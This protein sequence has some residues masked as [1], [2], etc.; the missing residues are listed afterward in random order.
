MT[1]FTSFKQSPGDT[2]TLLRERMRQHL[3]PQRPFHYTSE[4]NLISDEAMLRLL[5]SLQITWDSEVERARASYEANRPP[6]EP[7]FEQVIEQGW[8]Q[9]SW[10]HIWAPRDFQRA[11]RE[12]TDLTAL[13]DL[14]AR[15]HRES[16][17]FS[18]SFTG[19]IELAEKIAEIQA[20]SMEPRHLN[21]LTPAW[22]AARLWEGR[23]LGDISVAL[24]DWVDRWS[25]LG[26]PDVIVSQAW[27]AADADAFRDGVLSVLQKDAHLLTWD[28][29][30]PAAMRRFAV[31]QGQA[32]ENYA[33]Y[34]GKL[35]ASLV[36][37]ALWLG[38]NR[39]E[40][41]FHDL[42]ENGATGV[43]R[44]LFL[45]V[46]N[47]PVGPSPLPRAVALLDLAVSYP[48][49]MAVLSSAVRWDP[50]LLADLSLYP[51]T[52]ALACVWIAQWASPA[53]AYDRALT[54]IDDTNG[55]TTAF[56]DAVWFLGEFLKQGTT[57]PAEAADLLVWFHDH[58]GPGY[59]GDASRS[60]TMLASLKDMLAG[61]PGEIAKAIVDAL[62][63]DLGD[64]K[65]LG[66]HFVA[67]LDMISI[68]NLESEIDPA[69]LLIA[70][71]NALGR[72]DYSLNARRIGTVSAAA[73]YRMAARSGVG[74]Q[75]F[76]YPIDVAQRLADGAAAKYNPF[77]LE[78]EIGRSLRTH[79]EVLA[80]AVAGLGGNTPAELLEALRIAIRTAAVD[81][82]DKGR[83]SGFAARFEV[84]GVKAYADRPLATDLAMVLR[85]LKPSQRTKMLKAILETDEPL[86]L[87]Q[88][89]T[90]TSLPDR[91]II[92]ARLDDI[93]PSDACATRSLPEVQA[94]IQALLA[95]H[96]TVAAARYIQAEADVRT[97]GK[98]G[99]RDVQRLRWRLQLLHEEGKWDSILAVS[100]PKLE[101][102]ADNDAAR[103]TLEF[104]KGIATLARPGG[105]AEDAAAQF[106]RLYQRHR[107]F[108]YA[109]NIFAAEVTAVLGQEAFPLLSGLKER[110]AR[111]ALAELDRQMGETN[112]PTASEVETVSL[113]RAILLL[114][115]AQPEQAFAVLGTIAGEER[116]DS[117]AA[118]RAVALARMGRIAE[119]KATVASAKAAHGDTPP[120]R[121]AAAFL[122]SGAA[123]S[124]SPIVD[125]GQDRREQI[126]SALQ[127]FRLMDP[128]TQ[129]DVLAAGGNPLAELL[130]EI[131]RAAGASLVGL[132]PMLPNASQ[133]MEEDDYSS[134]LREL[135]QGRIEMMGWSLRDQTKA[136][137]SAKGNPGEPDILILKGSSTLAAIEAVVSKSPAHTQTERGSLHDHFLKLL[138]YTTATLYFHITYALT[139]ALDPLILVL[140]ECCQEPPKGHNYQRHDSFPTTD[141]RP[142]GF[143]AHYH[144]DG[145]DV[146]VVFLVFNMGQVLQRGA[147]AAGGARLSKPKTPKVAKA[148]KAPGTAQTRGKVKVRLATARKP[149]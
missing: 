62:V 55:K 43:S 92:L 93:E 116:Q 136:G 32:A 19:D 135:L 11:F 78:D 112:T 85:V 42:L 76:L 132:V 128:A 75:R 83:V 69:A 35:P 142:R 121:Q 148:P 16:F 138:G 117:V 107:L 44:L 8:L 29:I 104:F 27:T 113:N 24:R 80:R 100:V 101:T 53:S 38:Q 28:A 47:V 22:V 110:R 1:R 106:R 146:T 109:S 118:F 13:R 77:T 51:P 94:R 131:V 141:S 18:Q 26:G 10:G 7:S 6:E 61:L 124:G 70:Y 2:R 119:A 31:V 46:A 57:S 60:E 64:D 37:R 126:K 54:D 72:G 58:A 36:G 49:V 97:L 4:D 52:A 21:C 102:P 48:A 114:A 79:I 50:V 20:G 30:A 9:L 96:A 88:L 139:E 133:E 81:H 68:S 127:E 65:D 120:L 3:R 91:K 14:I 56:T 111:N 33:A 23:A 125:L 143:V 84:G 149:P 115:L 40:A 12:R 45:E 17:T 86:V 90:A 82:K 134:V 130:T 144:R 99:G 122:E 87:A 95:A 25:L 41:I 98:V 73:L 123:E 39:L 140:Q 5:V 67:A 63:A 103:L 15:R 147:A 34:F 129:A 105:N 89:S 71:H 137:W 66:G 74:H 145:Q 59:V 108:A